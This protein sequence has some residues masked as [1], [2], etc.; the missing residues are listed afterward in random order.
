M[1]RTTLAAI[2]ATT[3]ALGACAGNEPTSQNTAAAFGSNDCWVRGANGV[4]FPTDHNIAL[5][6]AG[7]TCE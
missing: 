4:T 6:D 1:N 2:A 7:K 5:R 3:L